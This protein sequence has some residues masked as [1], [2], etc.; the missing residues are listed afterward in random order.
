MTTQFL[1]AIPQKMV[2][3]R[4]RASA[5][6][7]LIEA[8]AVFCPAVRPIGVLASLHVWLHSGAWSPSRTLSQVPKGASVAPP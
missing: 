1:L 8:L 5:E 3:K 7:V 6:R 2:S 4:L